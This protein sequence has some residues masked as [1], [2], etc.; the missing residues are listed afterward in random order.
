MAGAQGEGAAD[1]SGTN[2]FWGGARGRRARGLARA[3]SDGR[4]KGGRGL[5]QRPA[6]AL[7]ER[8]VG[9]WGGGGVVSGG[10]REGSFRVVAREGSRSG[11]FERLGGRINGI[12]VSVE[13]GASPARAQAGLG[14]H[15]QK[16]TKGYYYKLEGEVG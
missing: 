13:A 14:G 15:T 3:I 1:A 16:C 11:S 10:E 5:T 9:L 6:R 4:G 8:V 2:S 12:T 7:L